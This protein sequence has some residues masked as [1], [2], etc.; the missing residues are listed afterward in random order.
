L[1]QD[2]Q[3]IINHF[4]TIF[5][6]GTPVEHMGGRLPRTSSHGGVPVWSPGSPV[7][8]LAQRAPWRIVASPNS[9]VWA[10]KTKEFYEFYGLSPEIQQNTWNQ[11][12]ISAPETLAILSWQ[13]LAMQL[14][15]DAR[16]CGEPET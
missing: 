8:S 10:P 16:G 9:K 6:T 12:T 2:Y 1:I 7:L 4:H 5:A 13:T 14:G 3:L 15:R 11:G